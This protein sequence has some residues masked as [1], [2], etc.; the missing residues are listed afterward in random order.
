[1][2]VLLSP[3]DKVDVTPEAKLE[4]WAIQEIQSLKGI[5]YHFIGFIDGRGRISTPIAEWHSESK[6][7]RTASGRLYELV[8][9]PG[10]MFQFEMR[11]LC[12]A[13]SVR[14]RAVSIQDV[15]KDFVGSRH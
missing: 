13:C 8:G 3:A 15:T 14:Y 10:D 1:M 7:G 12:G 4:S 5:T 9:P 6:I 2:I 11:A